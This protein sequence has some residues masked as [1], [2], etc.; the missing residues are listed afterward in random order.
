MREDLLRAMERNRVGFRGWRW[1]S[2][3]DGNDALGFLLNRSSSVVLI[4]AS[5]LCFLGVVVAHY[6]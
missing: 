1:S 2:G 5:F 4:F 3:D 6:C